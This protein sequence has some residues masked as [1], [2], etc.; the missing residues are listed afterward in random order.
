MSISKR[1]FQ[2]TYKV[3]FNKLN[4]LDN[5]EKILILETEFKKENF[6]KTVT[7]L[8]L[9]NN[10]NLFIERNN[11]YEKYIESFKNSIKNIIENF[12]NLRK[13]ETDYEKRWGEIV[14][15]LRNSMK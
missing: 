10:K 15:E 3:K 14:A 7:G 12:N 11:Y 2:I 8:K 13:E 1:L 6:T 9:Q 5:S 4:F